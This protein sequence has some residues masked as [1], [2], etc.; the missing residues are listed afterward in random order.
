MG[1]RRSVGADTSRP[2]GAGGMLL[3]LGLV[4]TAIAWSRIRR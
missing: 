4:L 3:A 1:K 2:S